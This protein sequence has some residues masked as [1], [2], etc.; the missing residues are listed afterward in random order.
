MEK[1]WRTDAQFNDV[2]DAI[3]ASFMKVKGAVAGK[4]DRDVRD[5]HIILSLAQKLDLLPD[6]ERIIRVTGS[7]GKGTTSRMIAQILQ[8]E[9]GKDVALFVSPEEV[10][11][12]DRMRINGQ[13]ASRQA[14]IEHFKSLEPHLRK[15][16]AD[17][18]PNQYLSPSG[19]FLLIALSWFKQQKAELYV[20]ETGRGAAFDEVGN[21]PSH[22]AVITSI[23]FEHPANLGPELKDIAAN[24][25]AI[26]LSSDHVIAD[27]TIADWNDRLEIFAP[28][29]LIKPEEQGCTKEAD[30]LP[31]WFAHDEAL[32]KA[33]VV[34]FL[35]R[36][37]QKDHDV[38]AASAAFGV[39][40]GEEA[41]RAG[42][43]AL[44]FDACIALASLDQPLLHR[45]A[46]EGNL[47][48]VASLPDDKECNALR[49]F[50][51]KE[52]KA[53]YAEIALSGTRGYL[54]YDDAKQAG[55]CIADIH[56]EDIEALRAIHQDLT[57]K[58]SAQ[59]I[60]YLGTQTF[61]RLVKVAFCS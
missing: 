57:E 36:S 8:E 31:A 51:T 60:Y 10:D 45:L 3:Y 6:P 48:V 4:L 46:K 41:T 33:A 29:K 39:I 24:K 44:Y 47:V 16:E 56:Y 35:K 37:L 53:R 5:P 30:L 22:L 23:L 43:P 18:G 7:K 15:A 42:M 59:T 27:Q 54:H 20:I 11:H 21:L 49:T 25:L 52:L 40:Q 19:L 17:L 34:T 9:S 50:F 32:A 58:Y 28:E 61:I 12:N 55:H 13:P 38:R 1:T 2:L 26:G 14:F